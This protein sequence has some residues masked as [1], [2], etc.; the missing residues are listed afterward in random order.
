MKPGLVKDNIK[1][2]LSGYPQI[3]LAILY[4]S[5]AKGRERFDSDLD[6][7]LA[8]PNRL[9]PMKKTNN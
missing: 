6:I 1:A 5:L 4:G 8:A 9:Q 3:K 7:A 2:A